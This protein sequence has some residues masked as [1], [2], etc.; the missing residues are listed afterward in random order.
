M[1]ISDCSCV[2]FRPVISVAS[3]IPVR[4]E[5]EVLD[6]LSCPEDKFSSNPVCLGNMLWLL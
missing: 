3:E 4:G 6:N 5:C 1:G 2:P